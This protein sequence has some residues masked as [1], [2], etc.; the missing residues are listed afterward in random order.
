MPWRSCPCDSRFPR[1]RTILIVSGITQ[2]QLLK[3][4]LFL[5]LI[6]NQERRPNDINFKLFLQNRRHVEIVF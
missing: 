1:A 6:V 4:V 5:P 3:D 2:F